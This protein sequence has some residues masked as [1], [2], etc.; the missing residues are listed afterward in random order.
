MKK[1]VICLIIMV[2]TLMQA[3]VLYHLYMHNNNILVKLKIGVHAVTIS[4]QNDNSITILPFQGTKIA[5]I[6]LNPTTRNKIT[7]KIA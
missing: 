3:L 7:T 4:G 5:K 2:Y 6:Y 1:L